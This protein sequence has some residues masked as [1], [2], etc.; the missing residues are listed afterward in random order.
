MGAPPKQTN[1]TVDVF[2]AIDFAGL[3]IAQAQG[4]FKQQGLNVTS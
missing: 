3:Y 1:V 4:L 2:P